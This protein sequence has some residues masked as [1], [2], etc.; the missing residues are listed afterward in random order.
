MIRDIL[1]EAIVG[2]YPNLEIDYSQVQLIRGNLLWSC[3]LLSQSEGSGVVDIRWRVPADGTHLE[4]ELIVMIYFSTEKKWLF[5][6]GV[7]QRVEGAC[8]LRFE[9]PIEGDRAQVWIAFR[10]RDQKAY[11]YSQFLGEVITH[12]TP[13]YEA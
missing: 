11:S 6:E 7:A 9:A 8:S 13:S 3:G 2:Q 12:N 10:S 1:N 4:D 5:A